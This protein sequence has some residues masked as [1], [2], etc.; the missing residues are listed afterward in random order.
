MP[1]FRKEGSSVLFIHVPKTGGSSV[2]RIFGKNGYQVLYRD[3]HLRQ[4]SVNRLRRCSPQHMHGDLLRQLFRF[5]Q[6][7]LVFMVVR[8]PIARFKSEY[9]MQASEM[10]I[11]AASVDKWAD[12]A[13]A[14]YLQDPYCYD[15]HLR[16]Q[17]DFYVPGCHVYHLEDGMNTIMADLSARLGKDL[18]CDV[19]RVMDR[20]GESGV[21]SSQVEVSQGLERRLRVFYRDDYHMFGYS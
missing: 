1:I 15:N 2:E 3:P 5:E 18:D 7:A 16:P 9:G 11:D 21:A 13:F 20:K 8:D 4:G 14:S 6:F 10:K 19:P 17:A 12:K